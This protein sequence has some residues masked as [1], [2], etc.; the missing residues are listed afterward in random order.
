MSS[1]LRALKKLDDESLSA[2][3]SKAE[4]KIKMRQLVD[5]R[6]RRPWRMHRLAVYLL[7]ILL[8]ATT[9]W[10]V[11]KEGKTGQDRKVYQTQI[12][13]PAVT[14]PLASVPEQ[15]SLQLPAKRET[16]Q[17]VPKDSEPILPSTAPTFK[18]NTSSPE[19]ESVA[20]SPITKPNLPP[21]VLTGTL[22]SETRE[23]RVALIND[24]YLKEGENING[25]TILLIEKRR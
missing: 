6:S 19:P 20:P 17:V 12:T 1:I 13:P 16:S 7:F 14:P 11:L 21:L 5:R 9:I 10:F 22:W 25:V 2:D 15:N 24:R 4:A 3:N 8:L 23:R 18:E